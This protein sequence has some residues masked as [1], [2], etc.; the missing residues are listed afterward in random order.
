VKSLQFYSSIFLFALTTFT[1]MLSYFALT[2]LI[3]AIDTLF[4][5]TV[6]S[7]QPSTS[8]HRSAMLPEAPPGEDTPQ[9]DGLPV[10]ENKED[11]SLDTYKTTVCFVW[12]IGPC[13]ELPNNEQIDILQEAVRYLGKQCPSATTQLHTFSRD[14]QSLVF[15]DNP[16]YCIMYV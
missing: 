15:Q 16:V 1:T 5:L 14:R 9:F 7:H 8:T 13:C 10:I 4:L 11:G 12:C 3:H 6:Y 2:V